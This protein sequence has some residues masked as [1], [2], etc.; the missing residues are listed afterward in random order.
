MH[1][2]LE[3]PWNTGKYFRPRWY[4]DKKKNWI[5]VDLGWLK[6][7]YFELGD[8]LLI[9]SA[10]K[11]LLFFLCFPFL[12]LLR[13]KVGGSSGPFRCR[14]LCMKNLVDD[15]VVTCDEVVDTPEATSIDPNDKTNHCFIVVVLLAIVGLLLLVVIVVK[16][17]M[18]RVLTISCLWPY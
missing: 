1:F 8:S 14:R 11:L 18:K 7:E 10:L 9:V 2:K 17:Y 13:K 15:L 4:V 6:Q 3:G 12:F 16:Y 5:L